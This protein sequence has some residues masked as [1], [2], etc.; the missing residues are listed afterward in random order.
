[1]SI[2]ELAE[3]THTRGTMNITGHIQLHGGEQP[4]I[5]ADVNGAFYSYQHYV[6]QYRTPVDLTLRSAN[7]VSNGGATLDASRSWTGETSITGSSLG[8]NNLMPYKAI[9]LYQRLS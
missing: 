8:H 3:H 4:N 6:N 1:M 2:G 9:Y 5:F 7:T